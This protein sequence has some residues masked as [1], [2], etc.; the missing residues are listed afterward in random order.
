M[1]VMNVQSR[2]TNLDQLAFYILPSQWMQVA[3]PVLTGQTVPAANN[4]R[5]AIGKIEMNHLLIFENAVSSD[6][7]EH[8]QEGVVPLNDMKWLMQMQSDENRSPT[9]RPGL[10]HQRD[11]F[12]LGSNA[13]LLVKQKFGYDYEIKRTCVEQTSA[14]DSKLAV[15]IYPANEATRQPCLIPI[16]PTGR[17]RYELCLNDNPN[18]PP[19]AE[20]QLPSHPG[21]VSDDE[22]QEGDD[23]VP[24][25]SK[26]R[27]PLHAFFKMPTHNISIVFLVSKR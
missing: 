4:W 15:V 27:F 3:W 6:E 18:E 23:L 20:Q 21:N 17:F 2:S 7:E 19:D 8:Q 13:W 22:T 10:V 24:V 26:T 5:E 25:R 16:P 14:T 1:Q 11:F 12:L 9:L